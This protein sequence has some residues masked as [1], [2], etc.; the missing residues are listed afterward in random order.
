MLPNF[1][2]Y[3][4]ILNVFG[5]LDASRRNCP[6]WASRDDANVLF[7]VPLE[8]DMSR[9]LGYTQFD[10][11]YGEMYGGGLLGVCLDIMRTV[12]NE[13]IFSPFLSPPCTSRS[14]KAVVNSIWKHIRSSTVPFEV[15]NKGWWDRLP[16]FMQYW[17]L[18]STESGAVV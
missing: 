18:T 15:Y 1:L 13:F 11:W 2:L 14:L 9:M 5:G 16:M 10:H 4:Y 8:V 17:N 6:N 12:Q 3:Q 7:T